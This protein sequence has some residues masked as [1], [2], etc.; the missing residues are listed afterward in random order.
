M[1][2]LEGAGVLENTWVLLTSDHGE[3]FE[4]AIWQHTT[5]VLYQP[6][7]RI[8]LLIFQPGR[9]TRLDVHTPTSAVDILP[10]L[11]HVTGSEPVSW[12]EGLVLPPFSNREDAM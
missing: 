1:S 5:P 11:R 8:P 10:T 2:I 3:L 12:S 6:V 9:T 4:R 7:I